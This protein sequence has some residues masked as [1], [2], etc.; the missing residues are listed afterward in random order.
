MITYKPSARLGLLNEEN[1]TSDPT[2]R[3]WII[4]NTNYTLTYS[5]AGIRFGTINNTLA[6]CVLEKN[7]QLQQYLCVTIISAGDDYDAINLSIKFNDVVVLSL[8]SETHSDILKSGGATITI[9]KNTKND[10]IVSIGAANSNGVRRFYILNKDLNLNVMNN[11]KL[12]FFT[13][14]KSSGS[15]FYTDLTNLKWI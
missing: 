14:S 6:S 11:L 10:W 8:S 4:D 15:S 2:S 1:F 7:T 5:S 3:G 13:N 9:F 12:E